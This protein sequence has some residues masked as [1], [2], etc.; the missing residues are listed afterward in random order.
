MSECL[1]TKHS[2]TRRSVRVAA[3]VYTFVDTAFSLIRKMQ[4]ILCSRILS[5]GRNRASINTRRPA[6]Q[7]EDIR[8][9]AE[10]HEA[11][12]GSFETARV[13]RVS[14]SSEARAFVRISWCVSRFATS[15]RR[16]RSTVTSRARAKQV[17]VS[18]TVQILAAPRCLAGVWRKMK[19]D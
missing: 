15:R 2:T 8:G 14:P 5:R 10:R 9:R 3:Y 7:A 13:A 18:C 11:T 1:E 17:C 19:A 4:R 6:V 12:G 16:Y